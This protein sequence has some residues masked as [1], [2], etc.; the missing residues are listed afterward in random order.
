MSYDYEPLLEI[1]RSEF[2]DIVTTT[3]HL[4]KSARV[5]LIDG[6]YF[7]VWYS[8]RSNE[9]RF[10]FHWERRQL[11]GTVW[12]HN[13]IPDKKWSGVPSYPKH[14]HAGSEDSIIESEISSDPETA[15]RQFLGFVREHLNREGK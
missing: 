12:R 9:Q 2:P 5:R 10:A 6:S 13:N 7:D 15:M 8:V 3:N 14:F 11:D 1:A 4:N